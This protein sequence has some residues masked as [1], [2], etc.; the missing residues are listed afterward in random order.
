MSFLNKKI[1]STKLAW[2]LG[3]KGF[4]PI[5]AFCSTKSEDF[6]PL[7]QQIGLASRCRAAP[8]YVQT[9]DTYYRM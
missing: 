9:N 1:H 2:P 7:T 3:L 8:S 4:G 5:L 6:G